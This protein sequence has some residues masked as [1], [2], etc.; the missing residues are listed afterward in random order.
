MSNIWAKIWNTLYLPSRQ[1]AVKSKTTDIGRLDG[2]GPHHGAQG[3]PKAQ[4]AHMQLG[5]SFLNR[6]MGMRA[7]TLV[8]V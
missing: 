8:V 1:L 4:A 3:L 2:L 7:A 5:R 6:K